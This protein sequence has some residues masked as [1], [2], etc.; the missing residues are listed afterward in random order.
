ML[1]LNAILFP[2]PTSNLN[3]PSFLLNPPYPSESESNYRPYVL[4]VQWAPDCSPSVK[5]R[6]QFWT[7]IL[8]GLYLEDYGPFVRLNEGK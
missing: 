7:D 8:E 2:N 6:P 4:E 3:P 5:L 1:F